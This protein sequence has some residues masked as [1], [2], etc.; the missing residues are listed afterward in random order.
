VVF[1][2][3]EGNKAVRQGRWKLVCKFP[4]QWEIYDMEAGRTELEDLIEHHTEKAD[5][6]A[7]LYEP[8]AR[9]SCVETWPVKK[10]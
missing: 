7:A 2:E 4:G 6:L 10:D 5:E 1:W 3:H 9:R 8:W